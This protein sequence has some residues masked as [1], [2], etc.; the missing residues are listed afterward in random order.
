MCKKSSFYTYRLNK[1]GTNF[2]KINKNQSKLKMP[3]TNNKAY[4]QLIKNMSMFSLDSPSHGLTQSKTVTSCKNTNNKKMDVHKKKK[5][6]GGN[7]R[8]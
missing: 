8:Y 4:R 5:K 7:T 6:A 3:T 1:K 2:K